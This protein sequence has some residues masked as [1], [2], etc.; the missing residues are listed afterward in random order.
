M[1]PPW[2]ISMEVPGELAFA[3]GEALEPLV[4]SSSTFEIENS[5]S[6]AVT[7]IMQHFPDH[8]S[9]VRAVRNTASAA[10]IE[11]PDVEIV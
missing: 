5:E 6:W 7:G 10:G 1:P 11:P 2:Q 3:F 8:A 4:D 9:L